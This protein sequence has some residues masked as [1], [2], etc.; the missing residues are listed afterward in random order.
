MRI[1]RWSLLGF[2]VGG[3]TAVVSSCGSG[4]CGPSTCF[5]CCDASGQ[6]VSGTDQS[7]CGTQGGA[8]SACSA[9]QVCKVGVCTSTAAPVQDGGTDAGANAAPTMPLTFTATITPDPPILGSNKLK[10]ILTGANGVAVTG[11][12]LSGSTF[13]PAMGHGSPAPT[14]SEVG[15]GEYKCL[16]VRFTMYG[17]WQVTLDASAA[18]GLSGQQ[19]FDYAVN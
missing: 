6:C 16:N 4:P 12:T 15:G 8:C 3:L 10:V 17:G 2:L 7:V 19:V 5:G 11:A 14:C 13:M 9:E 1:V 18:G